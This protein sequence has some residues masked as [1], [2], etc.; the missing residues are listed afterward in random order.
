MGGDKA[1]LK[2][3]GQT[4]LERTAEL[5]AGMG[6]EAEMIGDPETHRARGRK[7]KADLQPGQG[8]LGGI[9][10][11]LSLATEAWNLVVACDMPYLTREWLEYL[12]KRAKSSEGWVVVAE[13]KMGLEPLCAAYHVDCLG[14]FRRRLE[15]GKRKVGDAIEAVGHE[16]IT[17][18]EWKRFDG[19]GL[20]FKNMNAPEDYEEARRRLAGKK[21][22]TGER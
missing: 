15:E 21:R 12:E 9:V 5:L 11:A 10:T 18:E 3:D 4:M 20:L 1:L 17:G 13:G 19:E 14:A 8:P 16:K 2:L 22:A 6:I 7:A